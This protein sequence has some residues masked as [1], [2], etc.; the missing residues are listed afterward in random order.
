MMNVIWTETSTP[1]YTSLRLPTNKAKSEQLKICI[2]HL[3]VMD[4]LN[5]K[6]SCPGGIFSRLREIPKWC[7]HSP[8]QLASFILFDDLDFILI[9]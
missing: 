2:P 5:D 4:K 6:T 9:I 8:H 7:T 3:Q 1:V